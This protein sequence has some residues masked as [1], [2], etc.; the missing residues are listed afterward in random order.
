MNPKTIFLV[1]LL[2]LFACKKPGCTDSDSDNY[3]PEAKN[4][5]G[6]CQFSGSAVLWFN[7]AASTGIQ[8][9][10]GDTLNVYLGGQLVETLPSTVFWS[11]KPNCG[12][13]GIIQFNRDLQTSKIKAISYSVRDQNGWVYWSG[14]L[15]FNANKCK[16]FELVY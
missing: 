10:G 7:Q 9:N 14:L 2:A 11:S 3:Q 15:D 4:E 1:A 16:I 5:D 6:S 12:Q 8:N 13:S